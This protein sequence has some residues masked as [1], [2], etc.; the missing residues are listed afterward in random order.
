MYLRQ[1]T[2]QIIRFGPFLDSTDGVTAKSAL[3]IA[4]ADMQLS[5]DGAAFA[6]KNTTGNATHDT[7]GWYS[8]TLDT[9]DTNTCGILLLQVNVSGS[10][11][12]WHEFYVVEEAVY[13]S[14]YA[15]SAAG[16][17]QSTTAGRTLD[18]TAGGAAGIDWG[19][20]ENKTTANDLSGTDIQLCDTTTTVTNQ[21]T[22]DV[23]AI[24]GDS[25]AANNLELDYDGTGYNKSN[26][27][28]GTCTTNTDMRGTDSAFLAASAPTNFSD[29][30]ITATTGKVT[31]G[32]NDDKTGYSIS[33][34]KTTLDALN[35]ITTANVNTE[36]SDVLKTDT[37]S[38]MAQQAPP[39]T[40]TFEEAVMYL[41]MMLRN[42][43][44][45]TSSTKE[46]HNDSGTVIW[47]KALSDD[48]TT[49]SEAE[50]VTGP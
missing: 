18:V 40:P 21:V 48:G 29:L 32:T 46:F 37:I 33:G 45:I 28:I 27:T 39:A 16:P 43:V 11:P 38:E 34:T 20:I 15:A 23:T 17:L 1:S 49:Y 50:G 26:S 3:T 9:T 36:V 35:D 4:Q 2:S 19:N 5:K 30:A 44:D 7:D 47:K 14:M 25:V 6:Q 8:T 12:V 13:D 42:K 22:A 24:S 31:V 10:V 41:Y